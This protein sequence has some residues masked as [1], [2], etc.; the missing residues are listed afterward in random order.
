MDYLHTKC[1]KIQLFEYICL[2]IKYIDT[3][4]QNIIKRDKTV[5]H[6]IFSATFMIQNS[7]LY[8]LLHVNFLFS[9]KMK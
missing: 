6:L 2:I 5:I 7:F 9:I 8:L 1:S 3:N 4:N